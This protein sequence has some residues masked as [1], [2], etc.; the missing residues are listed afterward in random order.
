VGFF[1][2]IPDE[3][4]VGGWVGVAQGMLISDTGVAVTQGKLS[5]EA[6]MT[7]LVPAK[8][9]FEKASYQLWLRLKRV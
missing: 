5:C 8:L 1:F 3:M 2:S 4:G 9:L 6:A 7:L